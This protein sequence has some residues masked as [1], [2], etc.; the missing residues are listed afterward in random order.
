LLNIAVTAPYG[1]SGGYETLEQVVRHYRN[2]RGE[3]NRLFGVQGG[4]PYAANE[5]PLC[6]SAQVAGL[7]D[8]NAMA[9]DEVYPAA[10]ANSTAALDRLQAAR[11]DEVD[12]RAPLNR[13]ARINN[14]QVQQLV[15]FLQALTDPCVT[16]RDC[17]APWIIDQNNTATYPDNNP[18]IATDEQGDTL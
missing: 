3:V 2:P 16:D 12:A 10:D 14:A 7:T 11:N 17:L 6:N 9:C 13:N 1:H 5:V 15:A 8:K 4:E 18:L